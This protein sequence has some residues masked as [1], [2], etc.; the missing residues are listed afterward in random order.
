MNATPEPE[1]VKAALRSW[2]EER[3]PGLEPG[4]IDNAT[5]LVEARY[6]TSVQVMDLV[7]FIEELRRAPVDPASFRP[8]AFRSIDAIYHAFFSPAEAS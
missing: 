2:V 8:G 3:N 4:V 1:L 5:P 6:L 7:L